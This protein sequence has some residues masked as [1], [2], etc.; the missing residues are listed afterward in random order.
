M[1][2]VTVRAHQP[3]RLPLLLEG[4]LEKADLALHR[5]GAIRAA[6]GFG[7]PFHRSCA[8][9]AL[10]TP[11]WRPTGLARSARLGVA[12][13]VAS[14]RRTALCSTL[15]RSMSA[16]RRSGKSLIFCSSLCSALASFTLPF[17][18]L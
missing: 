1:R 2:P 12:C 16:R 15:E 18:F 7:H 4:R 14:S 8:Q 10:R 5:I 17:F 13:I 11:I 3:F 6:G 9:A